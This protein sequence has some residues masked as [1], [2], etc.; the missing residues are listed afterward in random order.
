MPL[1]KHHHQVL[2][3]LVGGLALL[4]SAVVWDGQR[5]EEQALE[6]S[7]RETAA[8]AMTFASQA[9]SIFV[10]ADHAL[11][12]LRQTWV[13]RPADISDAVR[14][15]QEAMGDAILQVAIIDAK[16]YLVFSSLGLPKEPSFLGDREHFTV[17][18][19]LMEDT[20]FVSRPVKG[21]VSGK[22][23]IQMTRPIFVQ[24]QFGGVVVI[25]VDPDHFVRFYRA[26][27]LGSNGSA[28]MVRDT[29]EVMARS[30]GQ[31]KYVGKVMNP[32][33]FADP[34]APQQGSFRRNAQ[35]DGVERLS[36]YYRLPQYGLSV[37]VGA[38]IEDILAPVRVQQRKAVLAGVLVSLLLSL[39]TWQ[40]LRNMARQEAAN[41]ALADSEERFRIIFDILPIGISLG[42]HEGRLVDFNTAAEKMLGASKAE[43]LARG[44]DW[45]VFR[46]DGTPMPRTEFATERALVERHSV[47]DVSMEMRTP[48]GSLWLSANATP[49]DHPRYGVVGAFVN[50]SD[51]VRAEAETRQ[52]M[53]AASEVIWL[54][55]RAGKFTF[56]NAAACEMLGYSQDEM[57]AMRIPDLLP[58]EDIDRLVATVEELE[59]QA[60]VRREWWLKRKE[61]G[62]VLVEL[63]NQ[64]LGADRYLTI[65][66]EIGER[67]RAEHKL[68]LAA[69][70]F[71][72]AREGIMITDA[73][74]TI[75]DVNDTFTRITGYSREE[76][77]G[78]NPRILNSGRQ[79]PE[80][81]TTMWRVLLET[82]QWSGEVWNRRKS[83]EVFAEMQTVSVVRD[84]AGVTQNYVALFSDITPMKTHQQQLEH[85]AHYDALTHLPNRVLLA[86]RLQQAIHQSQRRQR[87]LAVVFLDLDGFKAVNDSHGHAVGDT[88]LIALAER[89]KGALRE[90]DTL[91]R[92]GGDEFVAIL[93]DLELA[94]DCELVLERLLVAA[95]SPVQAG[96]LALQVSAS[97][98]VSICPQ[99]GSDA[100][101]LIRHADQAMY[102][103]KQA[104][105]NRYHLFDVAHETAVRSRRDGV[106]RIRQALQTGEFVL[107]YQP[108]VDLRNNTV[109]G[110]EALI[111]WRHPER[112]LLLPAEFLPLIEDHPISVELGEWV[113]STALAQIAAW[114]AAGLNLPVSVN[115]GAL[116]LQ[117]TGFASRL[118][119]LL[120]AYPDVS[121]DLLELEVLETSAVEDIGAVSQI[122]HACR[123]VG[124]QFAL[125]DFGTG[126]SSLTYLK[127]LPAEMIKIDQSFVRDML[128]DADD[129]AIV[130]GIIGLA[131]AFG[132]RVIAEGVETT[133][134]G[135]R[136]LALGCELVQGYGI[137]RPMPAEDVPA[138]VAG[139]KPNPQTSVPEAD[140]S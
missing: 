42:D 37:L 10:Y 39:I 11:M 34:G 68:Q 98:G 135:T 20:L 17:H 57:L 41:K 131:A 108:K 62:T 102:A 105:K 97:M 106:E 19:A 45:Q 15:H 94:Q 8:W 72:H 1:I 77:L 122:M 22:W 89:M 100:D 84:A 140:P 117:K 95:S 7:R 51:R 114:Q 75:I 35:A 14:L 121:P 64:R 40:L 16:G 116:Q 113:I 125:D 133:A 49:L 28:R 48:S 43:Y 130:R 44:D 120:R 67:K 50:I 93:V 25:S 119:E 52:V 123:T 103:A 126:Y 70:V 136:L 118:N 78:Q 109:V 65:G 6:N 27:G 74:G 33:P 92:I 107:Y 54:S 134:H 88:L 24:G 137:A 138:W 60:F 36:S 9:Q 61:W 115:V 96:A 55:D 127:H 124:V 30:S 71:T 83:G 76:A 104:G 47:L 128:S 29:G 53:Q 132:R 85:I 99:D 82:G 56:V 58:Q 38:S 66:H 63:V 79:P 129:M 80:Y 86:D 111:R 112:G 73:D 90:G 18:R 2:L 46:P 101:L 32:T 5:T 139:W 12:A 21:R 69:S 81:Y 3:W 59:T 110:V 26:T 87:S 91:A 4:W 13:N 31:E 23:S